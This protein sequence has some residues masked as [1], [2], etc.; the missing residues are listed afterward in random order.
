MAEIV[1]ATQHNFRADSTF[2]KLHC[3]DKCLSTLSGCRPRWPRRHQRRCSPVRDSYLEDELTGKVK[4]W[5]LV[6]LS[7]AP[8]AIAAD[9]EREECC[10]SDAGTVLKEILNIPDNI[11]H[12]LP[13]TVSA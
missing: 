10:G 7:S 6:L 8:L 11:S 2:N 1:S 5:F 4:A 3:S 9:Y 13:D 12:D